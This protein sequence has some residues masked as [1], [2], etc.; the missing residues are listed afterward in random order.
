MACNERNDL[1]IILV[2]PVDKEDKIR[3][4][5]EEGLGYVY[6]LLTEATFGNEVTTTNL[7]LTPQQARDLG[8]WLLEV[9]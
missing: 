7:R 4:H 8:E 9:E 5:Y 2:D 1:T 3:F 6:V